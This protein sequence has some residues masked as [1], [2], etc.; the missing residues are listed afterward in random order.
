MIRKKI[1]NSNK[2]KEIKKN[3]FKN[4]SMKEKGPHQF[5]QEPMDQI[6]KVQ[7]KEKSFKALNGIHHIELH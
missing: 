7:I 5:P 1:S 4:K 3:H 2:K 6:G